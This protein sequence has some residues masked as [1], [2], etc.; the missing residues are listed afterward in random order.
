MSVIA[1]PGKSQT[2]R[3]CDRAAWKTVNLFIAAS[4]RSAAKARA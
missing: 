1:P 2:L 4:C 3:Y